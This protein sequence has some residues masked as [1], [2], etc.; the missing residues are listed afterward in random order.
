MPVEDTTGTQTTTGDPNAQQ[1]R[2]FEGGLD[3]YFKFMSELMAGN[4]KAF[5]EKMLMH[6]TETRARN[7]QSLAGMQAQTAT[8]LATLFSDTM[9]KHDQLHNLSVQAMQN[10]IETA[11]MVGKQAVRHSDIAIDR[12]WN[13]D[14]Q[15]YTA[16]KII[17][18]LQEPTVIAAMVAAVAKAM[19]ENTA[20]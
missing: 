3:E 18:G 13:I 12:E 11:N 2:S 5:F 8:G 14:E 10:A 1:E 16:E 15:G 20:K 9:N 6:D 19:Q 7:E 4:A 17:S